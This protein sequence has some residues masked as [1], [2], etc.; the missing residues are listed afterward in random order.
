MQQ[1]YKLFTLLRKVPN[2]SVRNHDDSIQNQFGF[3]KSSIQNK[4]YME[5]SKF[6]QHPIGSGINH[7]EYIMNEV[8][9]NNS[10]LIISVWDL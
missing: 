3:L 8:L 5:P 1:I 7:T 9:L 6:I 4:I 10:L 2:G